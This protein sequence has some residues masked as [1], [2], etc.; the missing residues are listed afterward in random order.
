MGM[1]KHYQMAEIFGI[2][3]FRFKGQGVVFEYGNLIE[4]S[5][6]GDSAVRRVAAVQKIRMI[7]TGRDVMQR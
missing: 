4:H 1:L 3:S 2:G 7:P 6:D 5:G